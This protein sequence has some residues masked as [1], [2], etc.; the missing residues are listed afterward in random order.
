MQ[1]QDKEGEPKFANFPNMEVRKAGAGFK[2]SPDMPFEFAGEAEEVQPRIT[3]RNEE[4]L[5]YQN[6]YFELPEP[7]YYNDYGN[8]ISNEIYSGFNPPK[9]EPKKRLKEE[10]QRFAEPLSYM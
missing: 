2:L 1:K 8:E 9:F 4:E 3:F 6:D 7:E 10:L 5:R